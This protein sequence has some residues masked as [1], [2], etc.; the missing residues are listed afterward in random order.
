VP[1]VVIGAFLGDAGSS[2]CMRSRAW[3]WVFSSIER[4]TSANKRAKVDID[5][6]GCSA[7]I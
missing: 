1:D 4:G 7:D 6:S 3:I 5:I 2:G